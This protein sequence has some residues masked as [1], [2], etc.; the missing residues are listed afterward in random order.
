MLNDKVTRTLKA[1]TSR[2]SARKGSSFLYFEYDRDTAT[3]SG[4]T[5]VG[6]VLT[7]L[8]TKAT[9]RYF[10]SADLKL[11]GQVFGEILRE[12]NK[13]VST[14]KLSP[15]EYTDKLV[16]VDR[17]VELPARKNGHFYKFK[18]RALKSE[19]K[20]VVVGLLKGTSKTKLFAILDHEQVAKFVTLPLSQR[21]KAFAALV[22]QYGGGVK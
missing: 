9:L 20:F 10:L 16:R 22:R 6:T 15:T 2:F 5:K 11:R 19:S 4:Y 13:G 1:K 17:V 3:L 21:G 18:V 8:V 14:R 12:Y 7:A